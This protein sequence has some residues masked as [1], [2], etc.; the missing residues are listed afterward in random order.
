MTDELE[1]FRKAA[2]LGCKDFYNSGKD[3]MFRGTT[4]YSY[5]LPCVT[6]GSFTDNKINRYAAAV[7]AEFWNEQTMKLPHM[8]NFKLWEHCMKMQKAARAF[9][10][11]YGTRLGG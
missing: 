5:L 1:C 10:E 9:G 8:C 4:Q 7:C 6:E 11:K 3:M 2:E